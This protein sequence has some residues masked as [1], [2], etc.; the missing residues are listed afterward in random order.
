MRVLS[1]KSGGVHS[2]G[3][4]KLSTGAGHIFN[5]YACKIIILRLIFYAEGISKTTGSFEHHE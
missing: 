4:E 2:G 3:K 5:E 1:L